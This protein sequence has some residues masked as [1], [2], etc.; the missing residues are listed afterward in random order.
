MS[1]PKDL[2][3]KQEQFVKKYIETGNGTEAALQ[4]YDTTSSEVA[5]SIAHENL[6]KPKIALAVHELMKEKGLDNDSLLEIH[7][8]LLQSSDP[9]VRLKSLDMAYKLGGNYKSIQLIVS[10][11]VREQIHR[12]SKPIEEVRVTREEM[13]EFMKDALETEREIELEKAKRREQRENQDS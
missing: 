10:K 11:S 12:P 1:E 3:L 6:Q 9:N 8:Q 7:Q 13:M 5:A 4:V 2:T